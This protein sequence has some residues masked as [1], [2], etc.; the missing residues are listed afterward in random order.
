MLKVL[1]PTAKERADIAHGHWGVLD[2]YE[3]RVI[4]ADPKDHSPWN[5]L[6]LLAEDTSAT[7]PQ[8]LAMRQLQRDVAPLC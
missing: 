8:I 1:G 2:N 5:A 3:D 6:V 4:W 7:Y